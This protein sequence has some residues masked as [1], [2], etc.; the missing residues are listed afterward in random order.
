LEQSQLTVRSPYLDN[1]LVSIMYQAAPELIL[2]K[3]IALRLI[4]DGDADLSRLPTDR[5]VLYHPPVGIG[6]IK[7][8]YQELTVKSEYAYDY[9]MPQWLTNIDCIL[10]AL[11]IE[12]LFLGRHK[13][14]HFRVWYRDKLS[15]YV[16]DVLLDSRT[17]KRPYLR[18]TVLE[19]IVNSH[20]K[21]RRNY[22][23][24]IHRVLTSELT[25]R[26][27]VEQ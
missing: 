26:Q 14:Y 13:F 7:N 19:E 10:K 6:K 21:G 20:I 16:K 8:L 1:D 25:E 18:G 2:S 22:T 23:L 27:L 12:K 15:Q 11:H 5:G 4:A 17:R 9:G 24:E 3:E